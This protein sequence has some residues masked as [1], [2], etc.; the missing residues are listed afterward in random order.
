VSTVSPLEKRERAAGWYQQWVEPVTQALYL[1]E[2]DQARTALAVGR[3]AV[4]SGRLEAAAAAQAALLL[5]YSGYFVA[6]L[7][8]AGA[9]LAHCPEVDARLSATAAEAGADALRR[10]LLLQ[11]RC[12]AER[13][14]YRPL[15]PAEFQALYD[16]VPAEE[17][18]DEFWHF[19]STWA[20]A[21]DK[22]AVIEEAYAEYSIHKGSFMPD[23]LWWRVRLMHLLSTGHATVGEVRQML[24]TLHVAEHLADFKRTFIP[25][26]ERIAT[27]SKEDILRAVAE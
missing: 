23:W 18:N 25:A 1:R 6:K 14:G 24:L 10:R 4:A 16:A 3:E 22:P 15:A 20:F 5:D 27:R 19:A 17:R 11:F 7:Q 2:E 21:H 26:L 9:A 8:G 13:L 12:S